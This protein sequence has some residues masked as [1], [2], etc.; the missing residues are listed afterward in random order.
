MPQGF[1]VKFCQFRQKTG[2]QTVYAWQN[3]H[4]NVGFQGNFA[5]ALKEK[6][7]CAR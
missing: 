1:N 7:R 2:Y 6:L 4:K 3:C 5:D